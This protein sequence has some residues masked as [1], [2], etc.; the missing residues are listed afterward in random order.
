MRFRV[1][2][3]WSGEWSKGR[4]NLKMIKRINT[5]YRRMSSIRFK[6]VNRVEKDWRV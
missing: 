6:T 5:I 4:M 3:V 1:G 2:E